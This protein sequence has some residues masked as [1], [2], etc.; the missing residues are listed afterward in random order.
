MTICPVSI[1]V[2]CRKCPVFKVCPA[3]GIIGDYR[4]DAKADENE[5]K[6][7]KSSRSKKRLVAGFD[8]PSPFNVEMSL[9]LFRG[10]TAGRSHESPLIV[11]AL[12]DVDRVLATEAFR[13]VQYFDMST[14]FPFFVAKRPQRCYDTGV[15]G[16]R[17]APFAGDA[18][19]VVV[20][21][22]DGRLFRNL[23]VFFGEKSQ[24]V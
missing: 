19:W 21:G 12:A 16:L 9:S 8:P 13:T 3:K 23:Q 6:A 18:I 11:G 14:G 20:Q 17:V 4:P 10:G 7:R 5:Q 24:W 22:G 1:A 15:S 2:G